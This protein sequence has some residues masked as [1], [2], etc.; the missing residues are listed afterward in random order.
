MET[1]GNLKISKDQSGGYYY[2]GR[3][4][5]LIIQRMVVFVI[6]SEAV[7]DYFWSGAGMNVRGLVPFNVQ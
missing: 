5:L 4:L 1:E 7:F 2:H 6:K 3:S